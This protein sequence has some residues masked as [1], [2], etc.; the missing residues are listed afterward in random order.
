MQSKETLQLI[1][2]RHSGTFQEK[3]SIVAEICKRKPFGT[4]RRTGSATIV[5]L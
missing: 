4:K 1:F 3:Q 2:Q 5:I